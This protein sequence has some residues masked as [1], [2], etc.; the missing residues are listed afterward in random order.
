LARFIKEDIRFPDF[1][2]DVFGKISVLKPE[3]VVSGIW[4]EYFLVNVFLLSTQVDII[5]LHWL[6]GSVLHVFLEVELVE[7]L[8]SLKDSL[9][10]VHIFEVGDARP[11]LG[12]FEANVQLAIHD[13]CLVDF[14]L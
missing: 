10:R 7:H 8:Y 3:L 13:N 14:H 1:Q 2:L 11:R 9:A 4:D 6:F 12:H 5:E